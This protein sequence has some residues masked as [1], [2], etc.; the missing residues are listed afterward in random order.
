MGQSIMRV[1]AYQVLVSEYLLS[2]HCGMAVKKIKNKKTKSKWRRQGD[3]MSILGVRVYA[4]K[5]VNNKHHLHP[6]ARLI[7]G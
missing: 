3:E 4:A 7:K 2:L 6:R 1:I 5:G